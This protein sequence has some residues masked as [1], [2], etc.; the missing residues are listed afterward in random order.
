[1]DNKL[2]KAIQNKFENEIIEDLQY[3]QNYEMIDTTKSSKSIEYEMEK[4]IDLND[5][6]DETRQDIEDKYFSD[7]EGDEFNEWWTF[8]GDDYEA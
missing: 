7:F 1:M 2:F 4:K 5:L 6:D 3:R 8:N